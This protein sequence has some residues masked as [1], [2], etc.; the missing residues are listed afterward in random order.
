M[1]SSISISS[2]SVDAAAAAVALSLISIC[3]SGLLAVSHLVSFVVGFQ[4]YLRPVASSVSISSSPSSSVNAAA[5]AFSGKFGK[6]GSRIFWLLKR[7]AMDFFMTAI[8]FFN[9][10]ISF[11]MFFS[12]LASRGVVLLNLV[13]AA[14]AAAPVLVVMGLL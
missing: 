6:F 4:E 12:R 10:S 3:D 5:A 2:S 13:A 1:A 9:V 7:A 8:S 14:A 11:C